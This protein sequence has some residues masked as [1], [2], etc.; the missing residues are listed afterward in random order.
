MGALWL[1]GDELEYKENIQLINNE[2]REKA[3]LIWR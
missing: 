1:T 3:S 2:N